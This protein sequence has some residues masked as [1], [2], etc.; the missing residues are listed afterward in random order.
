LGALL[1][2]NKNKLLSVQQLEFLEGVNKYLDIAIG[3]LLLY[4]QAL[5]NKR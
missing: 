2:D 4:Q 1:I 3:S 5:A